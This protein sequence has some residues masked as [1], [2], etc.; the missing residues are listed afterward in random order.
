MPEPDAV[1]HKGTRHAD[2]QSQNDEQDDEPRVQAAA[3]LTGVGPH[4]PQGLRLHQYGRYDF[5]PGGGAVLVAQVIVAGGWGN[6]RVDDGPCG[7]REVDLLI[8]Q[9]ALE[10]KLFILARGVGTR[11]APLVAGRELLSINPQLEI[12]IHNQGCRLGCVSCR[13]QDDEILRQCQPFEAVVVAHGILARFLNNI[14]EHNRSSSAT[15]GQK[16]PKRLDRQRLVHG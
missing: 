8:G 13:A 14:R 3:V 5:A 9:R 11:E 4:C 7:Q 15:S 10:G 12:G 2:Q 1:P 16:L 6:P